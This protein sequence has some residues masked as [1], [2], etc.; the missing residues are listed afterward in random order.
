ME[1]IDVLNILIYI[2]I[3][4][5]GYSIII[6]FK[7]LFITT[8]PL[9]Y[10]IL[11]L[12][13]SNIC[14]IL[15]IIIRSTN[16][17]VSNDH[18]KNI[19]PNPNLTSTEKVVG[20][21][22]PI[23]KFNLKNEGCDICKIDRLP[24]RSHH[25]EVCNRCVKC[26]DHH[27][28]ALAGCIG[29]NN[30]LMFLFFLILQNCS[31]DCSLISI[32][33]LLKEQRNESLRYFLTFYFSLICLFSIIFKFVLIYHSYLFFTNQTNFEIFNEDKC[34]YITIYSN[35]RN[36]FIQQRGINVGD[37]IRY[38]P[39]DVGFKRNFWMFFEQIFIKD[40]KGINWENIFYENIKKT[41]IKNSCCGK[42]NKI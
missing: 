30:R 35:E 42:E 40:K 5:S 34:T 36:K 1:N 24:L 38:R 14:L 39:F 41:S 28:W 25:C 9:G 11:Q 27:C 15:L 3:N 33:I 12:F 2:I 20:E 13:L 29:E 37:V 10:H 31:I 21:N 7:L 18:P 16:I 17:Y 6:I 8:F 22:D 23:I 26:Y 19:E 4:Y 32:I